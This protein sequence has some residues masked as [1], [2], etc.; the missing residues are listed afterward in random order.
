VANATN[1]DPGPPPGE[2]SGRLP[3]RPRLALRTFLAVLL[4]VVIVAAGVVAFLEW[5]VRSAAPSGPTD[6]GEITAASRAQQTLLEQRLESL[7][8][9]TA[10]LAAQPGLPDALATADAAA[11]D[12]AAAGAAGQDGSTTADTLRP[13]LQDLLDNRR[14]DLAVVAGSGGVPVA[15]AGADGAAAQALIGSPAAVR[16]LDQGHARGVWRQDGRL[17]LTAAARVE[18]SFET[19]G[20]VAVAAPIDRALAL[21]A[22]SL[23][24]AETAF[25]VPAA[26]GGIDQVASTL[27]RDGVDG[28]LPALRKANLLD[29][30]I[31]DGQATSADD[32][33]LAGRVYRV[34]VT[35]LTGSRGGV[36]AA[37]VTLTEHV[38]AAPLVRNTELAAVAAGLCAL[39]VGG[40]LALISARGA[41]APLKEVV[42]A[43]ERARSG[44]LAGAS[45]F[46][47]PEALAAVF[48]DLAEK[49]S[50]E[51]AVAAAQR[52]EGADGSSG[53]AE[54]RR[55]AVLVVEMPRYGRL[56][57][58]DDPRDVS[59]RLARD[60]IRVRHA[61]TG[62]GGQ[63]EAALGHRVLAV[64]GGERSEARALASG[65]EILRRLSERENAFDEPVPPSVAVAAGET[66]LAGREGSRTVTGLPV[67]QAESL[68]REA[69]S[70]DLILAK[71][72]ARALQD[73]L[74]AAGVE[75][76]SQRGLL[77]PQPVYLL[78]KERAEKAAAAVGEDAG[79]TASGGGSLASLAPGMVLADRFEL[80]ERLDEDDRMAVP[81]LARDRQADATVVVRALRRTLLADLSPFEELDSD[82]R[83]VMR[84]VDPAVARVVGLGMGDGVPFIASERVDGPTLARVL[85]VQ[86]FLAPAGAL[87]F[88][89]HL[90][91][92][93]AAIHGASVAHGDLRPET[94]ILSPRGNAR[95]TGL[96]IAALL[97]PPGTDPDADRAF[98]SPRF[99]A[100]ER[101]RGEGPSAAA[102]VWAAGALLVE[103]FTGRPLYGSAA[104]RPS[105]WPEV[106][107]R[108][109]SG[110]REVLDPTELPEGLAPVLER[111]LAREPAE[112][113]ADGGALAAAL[114]GI[115][116]G[117][118]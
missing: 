29:P 31:R 48:A 1:S 53:P 77:T 106:R 93:L 44:D 90:A 108:I 11:A 49:R 71:G 81:F 12:Q 107:E 47:V 75:L 13:L 66:V 82:V 27:G 41:G 22:R 57:P 59:E 15:F 86:R 68:L 83:G 69:A 16:A 30:A 46:P 18:Q 94:V 58:D 4:A 76:R 87:R 2:A 89:R 24:R 36:Q 74:T 97:P 95:I 103:T 99:L 17:Y 5:S 113:F 70:G 34:H 84:A 109:V 92:G 78:D 33:D 64:F 14:L 23:S 21:E 35:P 56:G 102:D 96:G 25:L 9:A 110:P 39:L 118:V 114:A 10:S 80:T 62:R 115:R 20:L 3:R 19:L 91:A 42:A 8:L 88:A 6:S 38:G 32:V 112:R 51:A 37:L 43:A 45:R 105:D 67:Q 111:C 116:A 100:P 85:A 54:R 72:V 28:L 40:L 50:L 98:G 104:D 117:A 79:G 52:Q 55:L 101:V 63:V 26:G 73:D 60:L 65:A 7:A 61:V